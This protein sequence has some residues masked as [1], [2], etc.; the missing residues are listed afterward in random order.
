MQQTILTLKYR[1]KPGHQKENARLSH[2]MIRKQIHLARH[3]VLSL[4][5]GKIK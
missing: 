5:L 1:L 4:I 2:F 3:S